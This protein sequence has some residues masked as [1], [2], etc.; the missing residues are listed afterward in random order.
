MYRTI[1]IVILLSGYI[2]PSAILTSAQEAET[3][4]Q[5]VPPIEETTRATAIDKVER[6]E[7]P[8]TRRQ[9]L[10]EGETGGRKQIEHMFSEPVITIIIF[11][12]MA[13]IIGITLFIAFCIGRLRK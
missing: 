10:P 13:G 5:G 11:G 3:D 6:E 9:P 8:V 1:I 7:F 4:T 12:V 2:S